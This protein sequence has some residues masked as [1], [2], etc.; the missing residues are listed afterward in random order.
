[1]AQRRHSI[2]TVSV[3]SESKA[4]I[5]TTRTSNT[6]Y[7]PEQERAMKQRE[8]FVM[9]QKKSSLPSPGYSEQLSPVFENST[10]RDWEIPTSHN[11]QAERESSS[12]T[13][14]SPDDAS[15]GHSRLGSSYEI[16]FI[17][18]YDEVPER[19]V[20]LKSDK[21]KTT[22]HDAARKSSAEKQDRVIRKKPSNKIKKRI[23]ASDATGR[24]GK[25]ASGKWAFL[26]RECF[27]CRLLFVSTEV[28]EWRLASFRSHL[29]LVRRAWREWKSHPQIS[30]VHCFSRFF[31]RS[32]STDPTKEGL[33]PDHTLKPRKE[34]KKH[35][36][37]E[38]NL[39]LAV[40]RILC[41]PWIDFDV[42]GNDSLIDNNTEKDGL[43][44]QR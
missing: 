36:L 30:R 17:P 40:S 6:T 31:W 32:R 43:S 11:E 14:N 39:A 7:D 2:G 27:R 24:S 20:S 38:F 41:T 8:E 16:P 29:T 22:P 33:L 15:E 1:M 26:S 3:L 34:R 5:V 37:I 18:D 21:G 13:E 12:S 42:R 10:S 23:A 4:R 19:P 35:L 9:F 44:P 25:P 28:V